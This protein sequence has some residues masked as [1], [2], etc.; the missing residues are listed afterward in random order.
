MSRFP[1]TRWSLIRRASDESAVGAREQMDE[2]LRRYRQPMLVHL[3]FKGVGNEQAEDLIQDFMLEMLDNDLLSIA[4]PQRGKFRTLVLV[5]LDRF[6]AARHRYDTAAKRFPGEIASLDAAE[7]DQTEAT[8]AAPSL[9]FERA[10]CLEILAQVLAEMKRNCEQQGQEI[11]WRIFER[12][13]LLP[14]FEDAAVPEYEQLA[15]EYGLAH[16]KAAANQLTTAKRQFAR[17]LRRAIRDY[18][19]RLGEKQPSDDAGLVEHAIAQQV[20][21]EIDELRQILAQSR[22]VADSV[23][24]PQQASTRVDRDKLGFWRRLNQQSSGER[25]EG[26]FDW[27]AKD[28]QWDDSSLAIGLTDLLDAPLAALPGLAYEGAGTLRECLTD[29]APPREILQALKD[30]ANVHRMGGDRAMPPPLAKCFYFLTLAIALERHDEK[31][32]GAED[33]VLQ[34]GFAWLIDR[35]WLEEVFRDPIQRAF[36]ILRQKD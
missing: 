32:S 29:E 4:D 22:G 31:L 27:G 15:T 21:R 16:A 36:L 25:L 6:R 10:W 9:A 1:T 8:E 7:T 34:E 24:D 33:Q 20:E 23:P 14:L 12:R 13:V 26:I 18:V 5:A 11:R 2:L 35:S 19:T 17:S 28:I 30:W 3:R